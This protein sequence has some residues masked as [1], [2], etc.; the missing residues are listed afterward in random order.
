MCTKRVLFGC[1]SFVLLFWRGLR[2]LRSLTRGGTRPVTV[3]W[4]SLMVQAQR[5]SYPQDPRPAHSQ[6]Q[7]LTMSHS[8]TFPRCSKSEWI[9]CSSSQSIFPMNSVTTLTKASRMQQW[10]RFLPQRKRYNMAPGACASV[11][12]RARLTRQ[13]TY[14]QLAPLTLAGAV[15]LFCS[16]HLADHQPIFAVRDHKT[17]KAKDDAPSEDRYTDWR[18]E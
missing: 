17:N 3:C 15:L 18:A 1:C 12:R 11:A 14:A 5:P 9:S 4:P 8:S 16:L 13:L 7:Y 10:R 2:D 6:R